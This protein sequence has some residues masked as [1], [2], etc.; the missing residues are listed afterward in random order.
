MCQLHANHHFRGPLTVPPGSLVVVR[1]DE[2]ITV[3]NC[4]H[5]S[6]TLTETHVYV[7]C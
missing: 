7:R 1:S 2:G 4:I 3:G 5:A 6:R